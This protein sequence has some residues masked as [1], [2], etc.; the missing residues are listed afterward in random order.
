MGLTLA[1]L[2]SGVRGDEQYRTVRATFDSSYASGGESFVPAD[3]GLWKFNSVDAS[4]VAIGGTVNV[5]TCGYDSTAGTITLADE[6]P[7][8]VTGDVSNV[9][10]QITAYGH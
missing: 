6:T 10:V 3:V 2:R 8:A 1:K 5:A 7:A 9:V 4:I